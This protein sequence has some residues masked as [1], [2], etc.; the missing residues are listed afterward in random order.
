MKKIRTI[1]FIALLIGILCGISGAINHIYL[2][3]SNL[4]TGREQNLAGLQQEEENTIDLMILGDS[5]SYTSISPMM[6]W[7]ESGITSY[8]GGLSGQ[9][10]QETYY[11]LKQA[12]QTQKPRLVMLET[13]VLFQDNKGVNAY[14]SLMEEGAMYHLSVF[15]YHDIWKHLL[16]DYS[17]D[18]QFFKGFKIRENIA[19]YDGGAYMQET[20][21]KKKMTGFVKDYLEQIIDLC[22]ENEIPMLFYSAPSPVNYNYQKHN[23][24][25]EY[26]ENAGIPYIDFN[27]L[28]SEI[29]IDWSK[30]TLDHGDHLNIYGAKKVTEY[31]KNYLEENYELPDHRGQQKYKEWNDLQDQ[32]EKRLLTLS[33]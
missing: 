33:A 14:R 27:M 32:Y 22:K 13:H 6:L 23:T 30:D 10:I 28:T 19:S 18:K 7:K 1:I 15:R 12:L 20:S 25:V 26:T 2:K 21:V 24:L 4:V 8:I 29:G 11:M 31:M 5:E 9:Q 3:K 17:D 16:K